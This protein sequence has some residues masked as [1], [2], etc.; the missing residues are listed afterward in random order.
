[1]LKVKTFASPLKIFQARKELEELD[2][3]VNKFIEENNVQRVVSVSDACT[4]DDSGQCSLVSSEVEA[5]QVS[6]ITFTVVEIE[7]AEL[8]LVAY[9]PALNT[10]PDGDSDGTVISVDKP[11][12]VTMSVVDLD[13]VS[14]QHDSDEWKASVTITVFDAN[15]QLVEEAKIFGT[16]SNVKHVDCTTD[17]NGQCSLTSDKFKNAEVNDITFTVDNVTHDEILIYSYEA[18]ANADPD[19]DSDGTSVTINKPL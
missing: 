11:T 16:W 4:T 14:I 3:T 10:D 15:Q 19:G 6:S 17:D 7:H 18:G 13:G 2:N 12:P 1:M 8:L 9:N 5:G